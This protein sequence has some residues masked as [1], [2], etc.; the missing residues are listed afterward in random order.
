MDTLNN[1]SELK[2]EYLYMLKENIIPFW[3]KNGLDKKNGGYWTALDRK[4]NIIDRDKSVWFQGRFAWV[5]STL[6]ADFEKNEE[7]LNAAK[8]GIDFLEKYCFDKNGDNRMFFRVTEDGKCVIKRLRYYFSE[9]FC[10]IAMASYSRASGDKS[11]T[12]RARELLERIEKIK[13]MLIPKFD[14]NQRPTISFG[15]PMIM[16]ATV[17]EL[18]KAD[19]ENK[20]YYNKYIDGLLSQVKTFLYEEKRAVL[21][22]CNPD[23][24]LQDH[25]EGRQLN[26]GHSIE[27]SW[28]ILREAM[29]RDNDKDLIE[30]GIKIFDWMWEWGW[31]K[32]FG[33][34]IQFMDVLNKPKSDYWHDMK[35]WWPQTEA[36]IAT[37][38]AY[39]FSKDK[40]YLEMHNM[41]KEYTNKFIDKEYGEW[42]GYL[43][44]DGSL[45]TDLKGNMY[46]GPFHI[47]R[48]YMKCIEI[49][50]IINGERK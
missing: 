5:L 40:K 21:E 1:L 3:L 17:Q 6:Y 45:S 24:T 15:P 39:Y 7:Y 49:I 14:I 32:E 10:I 18:R 31:D 13:N 28:F 27:A 36:A 48:M 47:P 8:S 38:Y 35:F 41:V 26:P 46:K 29:E 20:E 23:G 50:D 16:L 42:F 4:G 25:F 44:R 9:A 34:I 30:L 37:L 33:G 43:H 11:Y 22:Q 12:K 19:T 2:K